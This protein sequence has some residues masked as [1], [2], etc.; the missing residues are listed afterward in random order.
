MA[1]KD[2]VEKQ[3]G[4]CMNKSRRREQTRTKPY[5]WIDSPFFS[6]DCKTCK[7]QYWSTSPIKK[8]SFC[9]SEDI[10]CELPDAPTRKI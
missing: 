9:D 10:N 3:G 6:V 2:R 8:C 7:K 5:A 4:I 1:R